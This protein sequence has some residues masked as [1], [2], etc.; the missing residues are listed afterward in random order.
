MGLA[1]VETSPFVSQLELFYEATST[2]LISDLNYSVQ[3]STGGINGVSISGDQ[4]FYEDQAIGSRV[5]PDFFPTSGGQIDSNYNATLVSVFNY[6]YGTTNLNST[7][8]GLPN[9]D[10]RFSLQPGS[11][12]G[13]YKIQTE[14]TF[15]AGKITEIGADAEYNGRYL[16]TIR[17]TLGSVSVDQ[18]VV[19]QLLNSA[20]TI[21]TVPNPN[22]TGSS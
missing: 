21:Q 20:P 5:T 3:N 6:S 15:Y 13:S 9:S 19:L 8:Y 22:P 1:V 11:V 14:D 7:N 12:S 17:F 4:G 10:Q 18:T 2:G 16:A